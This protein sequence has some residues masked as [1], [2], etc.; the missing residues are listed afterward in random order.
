MQAGYNSHIQVS[1]LTRCEYETL[2]DVYL[3]LGGMGQVRSQ[4]GFTRDIGMGASYHPVLHDGT[5]S[6]ISNA[7]IILP[8]DMECY[9]LYT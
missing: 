3:Q 9:S 8:K 5:C 6:E 7:K 4:E 1:R 2:W